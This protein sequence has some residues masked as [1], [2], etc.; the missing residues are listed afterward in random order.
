MSCDD[1]DVL[2]DARPLLA[3]GSGGKGLA[4]KRWRW[5]DGRLPDRVAGGSQRSDESGLWLRV[6]ILRRHQGDDPAILHAD[7]VQGDVVASA[8][9]HPV[10]EGRND[11]HASSSL[12]HR[13]RQFVGADVADHMVGRQEALIPAGY[14]KLICASEGELNDAVEKPA[15]IWAELGLGIGNVREIETARHRQNVRVGKHRGLRK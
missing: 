7:I 12:D 4:Q 10:P 14:P 11:G 5:L 1:A 15:L 9:I 3:S 2:T 6:A 8:G 13:Q